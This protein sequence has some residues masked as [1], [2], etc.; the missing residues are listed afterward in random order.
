[1]DPENNLQKN[2]GIVLGVIVICGV[3]SLTIFENIQ[4]SNNKILTATQTIS[5]S[6]KTPRKPTPVATTTTSTS[7]S[8]VVVSSTPIDTPKQTSVY[9]NGTY[10]AIGSYMSPGGYDQ[11][12]VTLTLNNDIITS[13]SVAPQAGD[14]TS[15]RYQ[16]RFISGYQQYVLGK[17]IASVNLTVISGSSLTS[18]GFNDALA[19][20][21]SQAKV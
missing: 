1:M 19:Q 2:I 14:R 11:I 3:L 12:A 7:K 5:T 9:K 18:T 16:S 13:V 20:I 21:K 10:S 6:T 17:N 8:T 15:A 4:S